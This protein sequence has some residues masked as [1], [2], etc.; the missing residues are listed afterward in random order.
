MDAATIRRTALVAALILG[1]LPLAASVAAAQDGGGGSG[2]PGTGGGPPPPTLGTREGADVGRERMWP[3]PTAQ[4]WARPCLITFQRTWDDALAVARETRKPI[5]VCINMD[6][7]IA[8]EHYAGI[9]YR[10]PEVAAL[11]EPYVCVIASVYRHTP[12]DH[13]DAGGRILC[14]RF[15]SVTCGEHIALEPIIFE[16]YLDGRRIAPRHIMVELDES[17]VYDVYYANDT[18]SVFDAIREGTAQRNVETRT[19]VRGDRPVTERVGS[20]HVADREAV[21][22]AYRGGDEALRRRL[23]DAAQASADAAPIDLLRLAVFGFDTELSRAARR[24]LAATDA[25]QAADLI[26]EALRVPMESAEREALIAALERMGSSSRKAWWLAVVN[27]GLD[28]S[29]GTLDVA[30]WSQALEASAEDGAGGGA[31]YGGGTGKP[32]EVSAAWLAL[33][34]QQRRREAACAADP[35]NATAYVE[36]AET[37]LEMARKARPTFEDSPRLARVFER[38]NY[39]LAAR[40][41]ARAAELGSRDWRV[42][43]VP[44]LVAYYAGDTE[45]AYA[46]AAPA[47]AALP[48]G[49]PSWT[50]MAVLTVFAESRF[51]SIMAAVKERKKWPAAWLT[52]LDAAYTVLLQHPQGT[53]EQVAWHYDTLEWLRA[54]RRAARVLDKGLARFPNSSVLHKRLRDRILRRDGIDALEP[55]YAALLAAPDHARDLAWFAGYAS[56]VAADYHRRSG[57]AEAARDAYGRAVP[58]LD[59]AIERN[60]ASRGSA[61]RLAAFAL[62]GRARTAYQ[63]GD[64]DAAIDDVLASLARDRDAAGSRDGVGVTPVETAQIILSKLRVDER[65]DD[66]ARVEQALGA[67]PPEYLLPDRP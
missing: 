50:A 38:H 1:Y 27:R 17:E 8:S 37:S 43:G 39:D 62:A 45:T 9:R 48:P 31:T 40:S 49:E 51:K 60:P 30:G 34:A 22:Q 5:L 26:A 7:E 16:K 47:V 19:I 12:R 64:I 23:L 3:A 32:P 21:E 66:A 57:N 13:D 29:S 36:L 67:L 46:R 20:R 14:P 61:D 35:S 41:A 25:P 6:G 11:Y 54:R 15:G 63:L 28:S 42:D 24:A 52:D 58:L 33:E 55:A 59:R 18:A 2:E 4:D 65:L 56:M 44:A 10:Q 53:A